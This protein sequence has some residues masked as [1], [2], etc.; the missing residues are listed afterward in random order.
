MLVVWKVDTAELTRMAP[1][2]WTAWLLKKTHLLTTSC[3]L[4]STSIAP[5]VEVAVLFWKMQLV[6][7]K[8]PP[9]TATAPP[10]NAV[11]PMNS[12]LV[13]LRTV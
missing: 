6:A 11:L 7:L 3:P 4:V 9:S 12:Q 5:P 13:A 8:R 2:D 10:R 1:P